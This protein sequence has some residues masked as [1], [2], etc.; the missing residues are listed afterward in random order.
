MCTFR[1][2][3]RP[4]GF[5][6]TRSWRGSGGVRI[7]GMGKIKLRERVR[8]IG[9]KEVR[10]VEEI[11][12]DP[13]AETAYW[14]QLGRD[15]ATRV[16]AMENELEP[17][18]VDKTTSVI[19]RLYVHN[20]RCL[21]NFELQ[22]SGRSSALLIGKNGS[23]KTTVGRALRILQSIAR[24]TNRV[25]DLVNP[26]DFPRGLTDARGRTDV[27]MRF[28]VEVELEG[29]IY[30]YVVAFEF[31]EGFKELR[32][33]EEKLTVSGNPVYTREVAQ[34]RLG[35]QVRRQLFLSTGTWWRCRLFS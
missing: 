29:N 18:P 21:E 6:L 9:Q 10:T 1:L 25:G 3:T 5:V 15:F 28:E 32:V 22:V 31:P 2:G 8:R 23:G 13:A 11:R 14:I 26:K 33:F 35:E 4:S 16:W 12:E 27:P 7:R 19:R 17:A 24:N 20:F 34:V 30:E